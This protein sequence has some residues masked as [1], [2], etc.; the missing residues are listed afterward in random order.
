MLIHT[1][2]PKALQPHIALKYGEFFIGKITHT[3]NGSRTHDLI[4]H[5]TLIRE[6]GAI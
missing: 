3:P 4:L 5:F 1:R 2:A 6:R